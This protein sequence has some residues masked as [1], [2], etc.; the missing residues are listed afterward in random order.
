M[1]LMSRKVLICTPAHDGR[2]EVAILANF[3][4]HR[5][6]VV[7]REG[8]VMRESFLINCTLI[9]DIRNAFIKLA[10]DGISMI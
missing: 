6:L 7:M 4:A 10:I 1:S 3:S 8:I 2:V 5:L 9:Q